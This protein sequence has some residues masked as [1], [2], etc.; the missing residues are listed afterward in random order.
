MAMLFGTTYPL[1]PLQILYLNM[2]SDVFPALA[3]GEGR[4][5]LLL[6]VYF[7]PLAGVLSMVAPTSGEWAFILGMSLIPLGVVQVLKQFAF[8]NP[9]RKKA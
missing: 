3:L 1:L 4:G 8:L 5:E 2:I 9:Y 6:A 7:Q